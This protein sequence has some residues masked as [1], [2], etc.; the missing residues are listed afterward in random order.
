MFGPRPVHLFICLIVLA[1]AGCANTSVQETQ[2]SV[3]GALPRPNTVLVNDFVFS[4]DV[5]VVDRDFAAR[6]ESKLGNMPS[7]VIKAITAK[8]VND[9]MVATIIVI[10]GAAGLNARLG[11]QEEL[12]P[13]NGALVITG[14]LRAVDQDNRHQRNP[15]AFGTGSSVAADMTVSEVSEG[16]EKQ[17]VT[18][19][20]QAQ[21]GRQSGAAATTG[22]D[23]AA[24]RAAIASVLARKS[25]PDVNLS[26]DV[27]AMARGLGR[28]VA[29]KIVAYAGQ[30]GWVTK[31]ALPAPPEDAK[32]MRKE[33]EK[34]PVAAA[35]QGRSPTPTN[36]IPCAAFTKNERGNWYV[37]GPVTFDIGS[38]KNQTLQ[39]LEIPPKFF[40]IGGV[41]LYEAVQKECVGR[42]PAVRLQ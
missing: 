31:A 25:A 23:A 39:D 36:T 30:Q 14:Q 2:T 37:K 42:R 32:P 29:D 4:S 20:A 13:K 40:T 5:A 28:A 6:L 11:S 10:V 16:T 19:T 22:P 7:D 12:T 18:F 35:S 3:G 38:A 9:E 1:V 21:S 15:V 8:R 27:E 26:P 24:L 17:L 34:L 33:P 41:D